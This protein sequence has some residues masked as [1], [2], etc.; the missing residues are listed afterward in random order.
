M[1]TCVDELV[2]TNA[3]FDGSAVRVTSRGLPGFAATTTVTAGE[4]PQS[5]AEM[6]AEELVPS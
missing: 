5:V 3:G 1:T 4:E 6:T 2:W